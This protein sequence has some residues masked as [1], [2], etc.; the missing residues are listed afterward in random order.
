MGSE[1]VTTF[2]DAVKG[3]ASGV[4]G[5]IVDTFNAVCVNTEGGL[6]NLAIWGLV[7]GAVGIGVGLVRKFTAKV[8]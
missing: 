4:A 8:G 7:L 6:S 3:F 5:A 1:I 2:T